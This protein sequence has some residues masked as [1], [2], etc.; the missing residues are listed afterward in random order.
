M[1]SEADIQAYIV[2]SV[3]F[4]DTDPM[5]IV[6]HGNYVKYLELAR[7]ELL[8]QLDYDYMKMKESGYAWPVV[9][10]EIKYI[11]PISFNQ[12]IKVLAKLFEYE[13]GLGIKYR[14][15]D[16]HS[17]MLLTKAETMQFAVDLKNNET[18][19]APPSV[20]VDKVK[21]RIVEGIR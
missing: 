3:P 20:F 15:T 12:E 16:L 9:K 19:Y 5:G 21:A 1:P 14:I 13:N 8:S 18:C 2:I 10:L 17:E 6:W 4:F 7:C 11:K